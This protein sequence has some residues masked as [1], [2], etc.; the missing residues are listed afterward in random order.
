MAKGK[1]KCNICGKELSEIEEDQGYGIHAQFGYDSKNDG[2]VLDLDFCTD[3]FD[4]FIED[5]TTKCTIDPIV[6]R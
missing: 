5:L 1:P 2:D 4:A 6:A 3:C